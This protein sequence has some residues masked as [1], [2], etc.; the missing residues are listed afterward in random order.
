MTRLLFLLAAA[1]AV[2]GA[3]LLTPQGR[4]LIPTAQAQPARADSSARPVEASEVAELARSFAAVRGRLAQ[5]EAR[6]DSLARII[7]DRQAEADSARI[8]AAELSRTLSRL[9]DDALAPVARRLSAAA[10]T[11]LY[12]ASTPRNRTRLLGALTPT[13]AAV[14]VRHHLTPG[15][16]AEPAAASRADAPSADSLAARP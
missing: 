14:F 8:E 13:Q 1:A 11:A 3:A 9:D 7:R 15:A 2:A 10:F 5:A 12:A 6:A 4:T 16:P